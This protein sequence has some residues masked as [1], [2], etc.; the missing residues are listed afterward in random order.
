M[1]HY[2]TKLELEFIYKHLKPGMKILDIGGGSGR[3]AIPLSNSG[4]ELTLIDINEEAVQLAKTRCDKI[5]YIVGDFLHTNIDRLFDIAI[6]IEV[7]V[8]AEDLSVA[9]SKV[10]DLLVTNGLFIFT[11]PNRLSWRNAGRRML[12]R[13]AHKYTEMSPA[14]YSRIIDTHH[15]QIESVEGFMWIPCSLSS[16]SRLVDIFSNL[17]SKFYLNRFLSQSPW[18]LYAIRRKQ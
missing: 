17:E 3:F 1:G 6:A 16:N 7:L 14:E 12:S 11:A 4:H 15:F 9:F 18:L 10:R 2:K 5:D 13:N 8:Y